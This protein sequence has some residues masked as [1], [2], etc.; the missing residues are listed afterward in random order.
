M[1]TFSNPHQEHPSTYIVQDR[2]N[3]E[4]LMRVQVQGQ[5]I[6]ACMGG[7]LPEQPDPHRFRRVLDVGCGTGEWL[8]EMAK[9]YP[10]ISLLIGVDVS[11]KMVDYARAQAEAQQVSD[12]VEFH[13][14]DVRQGLVFPESFFDLVNQRFAGSWLHIGDWTK[15][16]SGYVRVMQ[17]GGVI[18]ITEPYNFPEDNSP[19]LG[20]LSEL[21]LQALYQSGHFFALQQDG[22]TRELVPLLNQHKLEQVQ[23]RAY[24]LEYRAGTVE[25]QRFFENVKYM[26]RTLLPFLQRWTD[27][28]DDYEALCQQALYEMQQPDFVATMHLLTAWGTA[29]SGKSFD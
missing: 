6:T 16:L 13:F 26:T 27:V 12:R 20:R 10:N 9:T 28:P 25:L 23:T 4:E 15:L 11:G 14:M 7:V 17:P 19:A 29:P 18:R 3:Q 21:L 1:S 5:M 24:T 22:L 8:I 2:S